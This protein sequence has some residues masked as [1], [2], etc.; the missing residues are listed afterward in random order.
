[1]QHRKIGNSALE[2]SVVGLGCNNFGGRMELAATRAVVDRAIDVGITLF[3]TADAYGDPNFGGSEEALGAILGE[4]RKRIVLAS[5]FGLPM[6]ADPPRDR[7]S[8]RYIAQAVEASLRRLKTDWIDLYQYHRPDGVTPL[9]ETLRALDD[10]VRQGKVRAI[11]CSNMT[12]AQIEEAQG[13]ATSNGLTPFVS[14]QEQYSALV[15]GIEKELLPAAERHG[16]SLLPYFPLASGLLTGKYRRGAPPP[17]GSRLAY[18]QRHI[19]RFVNDRFLDAVEQLDAFCKARGRTL[20]EL[21]FGWLLA[22]KSVPSVI[23]GATKPEQL[24]ANVAAAGWV[25]S[26]ED[27]AEVNRIT[28]GLPPPG[29][30]A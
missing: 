18:S 27:Y 29:G 8:R 10:L 14:T 25:M 6:T 26:A 13:C 15:R 11:G 20:L 28:D 2:V 17:E 23:A 24:D 21:A 19:N 1:M 5:K 7:G 30:P 22:R 3:D 4:R 9:E 12:A 16:L